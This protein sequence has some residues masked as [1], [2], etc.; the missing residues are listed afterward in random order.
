MRLLLISS[1]VLLFGFSANAQQKRKFEFDPEISKY[2]LG[3]SA[4]I[5]TPAGDMAQ[6]FG[7]NA[8][9]G[10][11][12]SYKNKKN[13]LFSVEGSF[14]FGDILNEDNILK[15]ISTSSG[16]VIGIDGRFADVRFYERGYH[17]NFSFGKLFALAS[18]TGSGFY[19]KGGP[20]FLE[21]KIR[22]EVIGNNLPQLTD[23]YKKGYDRLTNGLAFTE[24]LGFM[25]MS[26]KRLINFFIALESTQAFTKNRRI[27][28]FDTM[29][30]DTHSRIDMLHGIRAG[31]I[32]LLYKRTPAEYYYN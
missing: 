7:W 8:N 1:M 19:V 28:N 3:V 14:F 30:K 10:G 5:Q 31:W 21:H 24:S 12:F 2:T 29:E 27:F 22:I 9:L 16:S 20:G 17:L 13:L 23:D 15:N 18:N 25:Y 6:R 4:A 32:I 11:Q 26:N